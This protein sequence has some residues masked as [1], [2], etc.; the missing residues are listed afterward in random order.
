MLK[1]RI[2]ERK[3][4]VKKRLLFVCLLGL[5][6]M[7]VLAQTHFQTVYTGNPYLAMNFYIT[8]AAI[9]DVGLEAGDEIGIYNG[10]YCVGAAIVEGNIDPYLAM[11]AGTDDPGTPEIDGFTP[12]HS[13]SYRLWDSNQIIE[14]TDVAATYAM[15]NGN[16]V[17]QGTAMAGLDGSTSTTGPNVVHPILDIT[18]EEDAM[19]FD[20]ADLDTVFFNPVP[21]DLLTYTIT[22][23]NPNV[24]LSIVN[25][26]IVHL[27]LSANWNG[28]ASITITASN[29]NSESVDDIFELTV[30]SVNDAPELALISDQNSVENGSVVVP[31]SGID[32]DF[33]LDPNEALTFTVSDNSNE[34]LVAVTINDDNL[35]DGSA[36]LVL[37]AQPDQHGSSTITVLVVDNGGL[38]DTRQFVFTVYSL[39]Q[40]HF[41]TVYTGNPYLAMNFYITSAAIDDVGLEAGD[42][43]GIYDGEYCVGAA[44]VEGNIDPYLAMVAGT[45]DPGTPEIDGFTPG[46]TI[47]YRLWDA[48]QIIEITDV[49]ATYAMGNG[50]FVS[51]GTAMAGL[52]GNSIP[53]EPS[54]VH[55]I[56]DLN[57]EEDAAGLDIADLDTVFFNPSVEE[58]LTYTISNGESNLQLSLAD[59]SILH[60]EL[61]PDWNG[62]AEIIITASNSSSQSVADT[63][64]VSVSPVNDAPVLADI[65]AQ[66]TAEETAINV[67]LNAS[68]IDEDDLTYSAASD[69]SGVIVSVSGSTLTLTPQLNFAG[70]ATITVMVSDGSLTDEGSFVLT[71]SPVN[72]APV[73]ADIS[74]QEISEDNELSIV[75][76]A[77]DFDGDDLS[78]SA[79]SADANVSVLVSNDSLYLTPAANWNGSSVITVTVDDGSGSDNATDTGS[80]TLSVTPVNDAP[81][82]FGLIYPGNELLIDNPD[83]VALT[84]SW[85]AATDV[86]GDLLV[87][88]LRVFDGS[89]YDSLLISEEN[90]F[91]LNIEEFPRN[92]WLN[93]EVW[94]TDNQDTV[95]SSSSFTLMVD[96]VVGIRDRKMIPE[97]FVLQQNY[98]N[99][100]NPSTTLRYGLPDDVTVSLVIYDIRGNLVKTFA[101]QSQVSGWYE[102]TWNGIDDSGQPVSTGL[103]I[104]KI[105]AGSFTRTIK[106]LYLK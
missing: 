105:Q 102:C 15:G 49:A 90:Q 33:E 21:E 3:T 86:D 12:G 30:N 41:Q 44:I 67:A 40:T 16:F 4:L 45:D 55:P 99:P 19:G 73:L 95:W 93:W 54:L 83:S 60:L 74:T 51:Q 47:S 101:P 2:Y 23:G 71:V 70:E 1:K 100:F 7:Q 64:E 34:S 35:Q 66:S 104:T 10:E 84:F 79:I 43:I 69:T 76:S 85:E 46:H 61:S 9:D 53:P 97:E 58:L 42:E 56:Q 20:V 6:A 36:E 78:Y 22:N 75:L 72:D 32:V 37:T 81:Q 82:V 88:G 11:V 103:Y 94:V 57:I 65:S 98:P 77:E 38:T 29:S 87:Y 68:D 5:S 50:N 24:Q 8:S 18:L 89:N 31:V 80:F 59:V 96:G 25:G 91:R 92:V 63:F 48:N 62:S 106:M 13:I 52:D 27:E 39:T 17:S 14:I 26:S 28:S